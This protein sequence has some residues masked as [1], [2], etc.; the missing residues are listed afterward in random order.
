MKAKLGMLLAV[1]L[2]CI[3]AVANTKTIEVR[4]QVT[5][6]NGNEII[7][8]SVYLKGTNRG[9]VTDIDGKYVIS[10]PEDATLVF[11]F[12]GFQTQEITVTGKTTINV[13]LEEDNTRLEESVIIGYGV[14]KKSQLTGAISSVSAKEKRRGKQK[15]AGK[16]SPS[17]KFV[18]EAVEYNTSGL[19]V[20]DA[21]YIRHDN[22]SAEEYGS[23]VENR[24][25]SPLTEALSTFSIDVDAASYTNFRRF[26]N[27]GQKPP[28]DAIRTEEF[29]NYFKY[30]YDEPTKADPVKVTT[31]VGTCPWNKENRLVRVG[32]KAKEIAK[33]DLP[34]SNLVF[35]IDVSGSMSGP[36][37]MD[38]VKS[39]M[40]M[41]VNTLRENDRVAIVVYASE[42]GEKLASTPGT[43]KQKIKDVIDGL[44]AYGGT[45]GAGGIQK[46]YE[47]AQK[48]FIKGGNNRIILCT[49]GD[50]NI[51]VSSRQGLEDLISE[52]RS[53]GVFLSILGYGM[54]NYK[55][56]RMQVLAQ[57]GNGNAAYIDN[58]Q[59][60]NRVLVQ[61][62]GGTLFTVAKDVKL[63]LEFNPAHVQA[64]RLVGYESRLLSKEDFN[65][66]TK[67]AG[68]MGAGHTVTAL[69][70]V[71]PTGVESNVYP[72][73]DALKY[74]KVAKAKVSTK[75]N[76]SPEL[77]TVKLRYKQPDGNKSVKMELPVIDNGKNNVS[78]DMRF[79]SAVAMFAQLLKGSD[80]KGT[81]TYQQAIDL[82]KSGI[83]N[84]DNGYKAEFVRLAE[85]VKSMN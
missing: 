41:L 14:V 81:A 15:N 42:V 44:R 37:R 12:I 72:Q 34:S 22:P 11:S 29:I 46:A 70:E 62:F 55:D 57:K 73:V 61:E 65:D 1:M 5:E 48:N 4:G 13:V 68:E 20:C 30:N 83:V 64:Y 82:A 23:Y 50:F 8:V 47:I 3:S 28:K 75:F 58:L 76:S 19:M 36:T 53:S 66:D 39:S 38:L 6:A 2:L 85:I 79:A 26:I 54:G 52:K 7:G 49:D 71:I 51:G 25:I 27:Q 33:E 45:N 35:L 16:P 67:D 78:S 84:D 21:A 77:L 31:E 18:A 74:Q 69:Y 17:S 9:V 24:F 10:V 56:D 59:E 80:F 32:I 40:K 60:A 43:E 63:Q